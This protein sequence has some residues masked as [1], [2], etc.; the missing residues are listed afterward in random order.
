[1][2][3]KI[4]FLDLKDINLK[5]S[6]E[7]LVAYKKVINSG[8]YVLGPE[9]ELFEAEFANYCDSKFCIGTSNGLDSLILLLKAY[10]I[11]PGDE[12]IVPSHTFIA[13]WLSV[14]NVGAK[15]I[16]VEPD[17]HSF[18]INTQKI[19]EKITDKTRAIIPVH[20]Y[21]QAADMAKIK[22]VAD[23]NNLIVIEDAA[24]AHGAIYNQKKVGSLGMGAAFSFYP[25]KN[26]GALGDGGAITISDASIYK[27]IK[28]YRNYGSDIK[29]K[30]DVVGGNNRLDELQAAFLRVKLKHLD[31]S[32]F[33]RRKIASI[34]NSGIDNTLIKK[35]FSKESSNHVWHLY[36]IRAKER[37]RLADYLLACGVETLIHYPCPPHKQKC[38][39]E[40]YDDEKLSETLSNEVLSLPISPSMSNEDALFVV[41]KV[42]EFK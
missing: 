21:G 24:Q 36:V 20:L 34:Y 40:D 12:V 8:Y 22:I 13:T 26:L 3:K 32:I 31:E 6:D 41:D 27:A 11:G 30:H 5:V 33:N 35:P 25:G 17:L 28:K 2:K 9:L 42:N 23:E 37:K 10:D 7:L 1:M 38:Y 29:Y 15:P 19:I 16:P 39:S 14:T 18:N 4:P